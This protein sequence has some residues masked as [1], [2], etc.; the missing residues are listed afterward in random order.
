MQKILLSEFCEVLDLEVLYDKGEEYITLDTPF[1][2][3][4]G[5][6]QNVHKKKMHKKWRM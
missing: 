3:R 6:Q 1:I 4:P 2:T 5:I